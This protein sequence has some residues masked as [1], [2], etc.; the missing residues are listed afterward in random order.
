MIKNVVFSV[1][2][3]VTYMEPV[4]PLIG[5]HYEGGAS[6]LLRHRP[7]V[8]A[9]PRASVASGRGPRRRLQPP[10]HRP[11]NRLVERPRHG[12]RLRPERESPA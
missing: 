5:R 11:D 3:V 12:P 7:P 10:G 1:V 6:V 4:E 2:H 9:G 8:L